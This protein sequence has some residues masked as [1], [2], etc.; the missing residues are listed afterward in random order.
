MFLSVYLL[1]CLYTVQHLSPDGG[2]LVARLCPSPPVS[3]VHGISQAKIPEWVAISFFRGSSGPGIEPCL[4]H[5]RWVLYCWPLG[6]AHLS[7]SRKRLYF[8]HNQDN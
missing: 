5:S 8:S 4:L 2:G 6:K 7:A 3:S 1:F